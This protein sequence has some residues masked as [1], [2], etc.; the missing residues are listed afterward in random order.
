MMLRLPAVLLLCLGCLLDAPGAAAAT[1]PPPNVLLLFVDNLGYGDLKTYGHPVNRTPHL[2][3]LAA[4]GVRCTDFYV[5]APSCAPSRGAIL[6]G[7]HPERTGFNYQ[8]LHYARLPARN[9]GEGLPAAE[10]IIPAFLK[11]LGYATAAFG[12]WNAGFNPG[13]RP[14]ERGFDEFLGVEGGNTGYY[15]HRYHRQNDMRRGTEPVD[16]Q[17]QY[18]T[19]IFADAAIDFIRRH[20]DRPW[21][22]YLPFNAVHAPT[23]AN[24]EPGERIEWQAPEKYF[25]LHGLRPDEPD[26][27]KRFRAVLS[28]LDDAI[29]RVLATV[30]DLRQRER[31][32]VL[33][34]S[35][36]GAFPNQLPDVGS[37]E[38]SN[39]P[40]RGGASSTYE[41]G[42]RVP[43]F[44]R[45]PGR[46]APGS[47]CRELLSTLDVLP[48][49]ASAADAALP[50][51]LTLDGRDPIR[52]L[53]GEA[54]SPHAALHWVWKAGGAHHWQAMREG[55]FKL[56][57]SSP[58][59]PWEL[60][61]LTRDPGEASDL[62]ASRPELAAA[63][64]ARFERWHAEVRPAAR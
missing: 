37:G 59:K 33:F 58:Q 3:R 42:I 14:T 6:S 46:I 4:D 23:H 18:S 21:F 43:A 49:I 36:N 57:R 41:G 51:G 8:A 5:A 22:V 30:D 53:A 50:P 7:R 52:V 40:F 2:D 55:A 9:G 64:A 17:G 26:P 29:G 56:I 44:F 35:D 11:P 31:T 16:L 13:S 10:K 25:A 28:A 47:T 63:M 60:Y 34:I 54:T 19:D 20:R 48:L 32:I 62:A 45:W 38:Q 61:D 27:K 39:A 15:T 24:V 12:K 1:V